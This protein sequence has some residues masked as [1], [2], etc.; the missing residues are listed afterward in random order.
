M[1]PWA[2]L[3]L[4]LVLS[5][6][7]GRSCESVA[8]DSAQ[9]LS[10]D[11]WPFLRGPDYDGHST[12]T[13]LADS[14]SSAGPPLLWARQLGQGYSGFVAAGERIYTQYQT[15]SG[16]VV[17]CLDAGTGD[18]VWTY[19]YDW[20]F[21]MTGLYPGPR[22]TPTLADNHVYFSG[23]SGLVGCLTD[24]GR[25]VWSVNVVKEFQGK[26]TG[27][28]Y[29]CTPVVEQGKV[30]LAVGG[31]GASLV[32]LNAGDGSTIW[33]AGD[34]SASYVPVLPIML[35]GRR[36]VV[37]L[38]ENALVGHDLDTGRRLW[39]REISQGYSEHAAWPIYSE[40]YLW[41]SGPFR[42]GSQLLEL[43]AEGDELRH[44]WQGRLL[45]N[46]VCSS[47]L[48]DGCLYGF[49]LHEAQSKLHRGSRGTFRCLD[50]LSGKERWSTTQTGQASAL[51]ADGKLL[52][53]N[54]LGELILA[55]A[56]ADHYEE[57]GRASLLPGEICWTA[58]LL[59]R[60]RL[61]VRSQTRA[62]CVY[63]GDPK[64]FSP[65][66]DRPALTIASIPRQAHRDLTPLLGVE[67]EYAFDVPTPAWFR[68]WFV[69]GLAIMGVAVAV[70][71]VVAGAM[72]LVLG[73]LPSIPVVRWM[74]WG[75]AF[76][77]AA[78][79]TTLLSRWYNDFVFTWPLALFVLY[80][81]TVEQA[82]GGK[83]RLSRRAIAGSYAVVLC[84]LGGCMAYYALCR[85]L[86]LVTEWAFLCGFP[87]ALPIS[88]ARLRLTRGGRSL[89]GVAP[90]LIGLEYT[91]YYWSSVAV[92]LWRCQIVGGP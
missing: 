43:P 9:P 63:L 89:P 67:P 53:F 62:V 86:S 59:Y 72:R 15:L 29:A 32:A 87:G 55:R 34:D 13:G 20:P 37:G 1:R 47:V 83:A 84:F 25:L 28:G 78:A 36:Q 68:L 50:F 76:L 74:F 40:P 48:H 80:Q 92:L 52:L 12:E 14:W 81:V 69:T 82:R 7:D 31:K 85:Q 23:P 39:R 19:R 60:R 4:I 38:L 75:G 88:A 49:D 51:V 10:K 57:L 5:A 35:N 21:E 2:R 33:Q 22:A 77:L 54:D 46:D 90:L 16:Q 18:T 64:H 79:G 17:A 45:S 44:V 6:A 3:L 58:P 61:Y 66:T 30:L 91:A 71:G 24:E 11:A 26:G 42:S 41:F 8:A 73:R 27:F 65:P 70:V 56:D